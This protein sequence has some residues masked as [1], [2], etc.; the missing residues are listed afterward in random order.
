MCMRA[1]VV[2]GGL[3]RCTHLEA[4]VGPPHGAVALEAAA[5]AQLPDA[6]AALHAAEHLLVREHVPERQ[7]RGGGARGAGHRQV[8]GVARGVHMHA[9]S[10]TC[11]WLAGWLVVTTAHDGAV[12]GRACTHALAC[13]WD[14]CAHTALLPITGRCLCPPAMQRGGAQAL[15]SASVLHRRQAGRQAQAPCRS[16]SGQ[17]GHGPWRHES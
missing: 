16:G 4:A 17:A 13:A 5:K 6:L 15:H 14:E 9:G 8:S 2:A 7:E 12:T 3:R 11:G 10:K 1:S